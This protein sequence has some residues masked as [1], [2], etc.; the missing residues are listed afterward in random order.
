MS[1]SWREDDSL[2]KWRKK[3]KESARGKCNR[4]AK[5]IPHQEAMGKYKYKYKG[6]KIIPKRSCIKKQWA[7]TN[8]KANT[9]PNF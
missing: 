8:K 9:L 3:C 1:S 4:G 7:N 6:V 2:E 5:F